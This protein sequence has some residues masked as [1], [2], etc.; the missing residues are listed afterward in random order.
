LLDGSSA[1]RLA[2]KIASALA[3]SPLSLQGQEIVAQ[4]SIGIAL[5]PETASSPEAL[6]SAADKAM[7]RSKR[8]GLPYCMA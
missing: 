1:P 6:L 3:S 5:Y 2:T 7:Y 4:T 8:E